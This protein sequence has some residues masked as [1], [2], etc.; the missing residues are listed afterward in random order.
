MS[1]RRPDGTLNEHAAFARHSVLYAAAAAGRLAIDAVYLDIGD[2]DGLAREARGAAE[3]GFDVKAVIHPSHC[4]AVRAAFT[5]TPDQLRAAQ[6][7]LDAAA[8]SAHG[9]FSLDGRHIDEPLIRQARRVLARGGAT[10]PRS[11]PR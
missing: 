3:A 10:A 1:S 6:R 9:V 4:A 5:A 8:A 2:L 11:T 7:I